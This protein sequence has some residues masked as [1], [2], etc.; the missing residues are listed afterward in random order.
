MPARNCVVRVTISDG[1][2]RILA[3]KSPAKWKRQIM[4]QHRHAAFGEEPSIITTQLHLALFNVVDLINWQQLQELLASE[5][6]EATHPDFA[7]DYMSRAE[8][9][10]TFEVLTANMIQLEIRMQNALGAQ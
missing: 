9:E 10:Y 7:A 1:N 5:V 2:V 3:R 6:R 8:K 4:R